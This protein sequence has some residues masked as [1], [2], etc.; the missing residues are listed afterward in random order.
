MTCLA[1]TTNKHNHSALNTEHTVH[2]TTSTQLTV[3]S[4]LCVACWQAHSLARWL[5]HRL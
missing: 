3:Y 5:S 2:S 1:H 4:T